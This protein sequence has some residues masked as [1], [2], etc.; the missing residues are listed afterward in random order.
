MRVAFRRALG[1]SPKVY[2]SR[3]CRPRLIDDL[4]RGTEMIKQR[5][6]DDFALRFGVTSCFPTTPTTT[7]PAGSSTP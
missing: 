5:A 6:L 3:F 2:R 1:V 7:P 4:Q